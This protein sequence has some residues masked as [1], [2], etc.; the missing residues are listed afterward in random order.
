MSSL[1]DKL[2]NSTAPSPPK[3]IVYGQ[4]GVGKTTFAAHAKA[5]LID[6]E[7]G[8]GNI[9]GVPRTPYLETWPEMLEWLGAIAT[10][11]KME[12]RVVA[13]D[14]IDWMLQRIAQHV[15]MALDP[16]TKNDVTNT[17]ASAHGGYFKAREIVANIVSIELLPLLNKIVRRGCAVILL[18][19]AEHGK[20]TTPEGFTIRRAS[21]D[22]PSFVMPTFIEWADAVLYLYIA[23]DTRAIKATSTNT[24]LAKN[25][26]GMPEDMP[27]DFAS[28]AAAIKAARTAH[29]KKGS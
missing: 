20:E 22:L 19:H 14:T 29:E 26:Y 13:I 24:V 1:L 21:P 17:L 28:V 27:G 23:G 15:T 7:G 9:V 10:E 18:A 5:L 8:A 12:H 2:A 16:K 3:I 6:C 25:R 4:P 11:P